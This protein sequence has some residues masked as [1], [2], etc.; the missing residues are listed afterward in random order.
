MWPAC[1]CLF[2]FTDKHNVVRLFKATESQFKFCNN[3][4]WCLLHSYGFDFSVWEIFGALLFGG[5]LVIPTKNEILSPAQLYNFIE[6]NN[7]TIL[8][9]TPSALKMVL[10]EWDHIL[11]NLKYIISGGEALES[12]VIR[13]WSLCVNFPISKLINMYGI[14]FNFPLVLGASVDLPLHEP[15]LVERYADINAESVF[16]K[17]AFG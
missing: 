5:T 9:Q 1:S 17:H 7:V 2:Y 14:T 16:S 13:E 15:T 3:D 4:I 10:K 12:S 11:P 6:K 8:N